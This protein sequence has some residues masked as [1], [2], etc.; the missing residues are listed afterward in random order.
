MAGIAS[1]QWLVTL[2]FLNATP[3]GEVDPIFGRDAAF[4]IFTLPFLDFARY[5]V[6]AVMTLAFI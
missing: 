1:S 2:Q 6:L 3:F 4:Y 5:M